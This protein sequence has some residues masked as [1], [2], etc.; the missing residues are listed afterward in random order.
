VPSQVLANG[1]KVTTDA[2]EQIPV[3]P[4]NW[5]RALVPRSSRLQSDSDDCWSSRKE[6]I[7]ES[8]E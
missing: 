1:S 2:D 5:C 3:E 7:W 4:Q 8:S 6:T